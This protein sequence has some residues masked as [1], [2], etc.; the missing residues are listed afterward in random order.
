M[1]DDFY[2]CGL[3]LIQ[4]VFRLNPNIHFRNFTR[5]FNWEVHFLTITTNIYNQRESLT[6]MFFLAKQSNDISVVVCKILIICKIF[7]SR[8]PTQ[9][10]QFLQ[11]S[12]NI[13]IFRTFQL[14]LMIAIFISSF[15]II[16]NPMVIDFKFVLIVTWR[17]FNIN[18]ES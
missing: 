13:S 9:F 5:K 1:I 2:V 18:L 8:L 10:S 7:L 14:E 17:Q 4:I 16:V 11:I 3:S 12:M 6:S 15:S